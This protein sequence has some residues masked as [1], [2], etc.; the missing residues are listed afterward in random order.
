MGIYGIWKSSPG[1]WNVLQGKNNGWLSWLL[2][3]GVGRNAATNDGDR[4][5]STAPTVLSLRNLPHV[6]L[7]GSINLAKRPKSPSFAVQSG[8]LDRTPCNCRYINQ[9]LR[10]S[11][12]YLKPFFSPRPSLTCYEPTGPCPGALRR[13]AS[14]FSPSVHLKACQHPLEDAAVHTILDGLRKLQGASWMF[15]DLRLYKYPKQLESKN[16]PNI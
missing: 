15:Q 5:T 12:T 2:D 14:P 13:C 6:P 16:P 9:K 4:H 10:I 1:F 11:Q 8:P 3:C 7:W